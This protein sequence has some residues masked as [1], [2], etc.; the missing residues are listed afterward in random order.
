[1]MCYGLS[2]A[3]GYAILLKFT[4]SAVCL[5]LA[6]VGAVIVAVWFKKEVKLLERP[7]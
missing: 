2:L 4:H 3:I 7:L 1:M 6:V 5:F